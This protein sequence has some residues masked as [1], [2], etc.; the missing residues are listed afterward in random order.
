MSLDAALTVANSGLA[1]INRQF[2]LIS[3]NVANASTPS[4]AAEIGGQTALTA[5][6]V[7]LG[8]RSLPATR[9][10]DASLQGQLW[11]QNADVSAAQTRQTA[12]AAIDAAS[13]TTGA[14]NDIASLLGKLQ[15]AFSTLAND[16]S[17][18]T[19]QNAV[20]ADAASLA[21]GINTLSSAVS[22]ARQAA[23]DGIVS[24]IG[25]LNSALTQIGT[26]SDQIIAARA[27]GQ[28]TADLENQRDGVLANISQLIE[29]KA[30]A[31][32][33]GDMVLITPSGL[34]LPTRGGAAFSTQEAN[35]APGAWYPG[36]GVPA[37]T[38]NGV[39]V[40][41]QLQGGSIGAN[42]GLRDASL[43]IYQAGLDE[44]AQNIA[45]RFDAQGLRLFSDPAGNV[46]ASAGAPVQG[47]YVGFA[48]TI[49]V[50][51]A[52]SAQ[53]SL[54]RDGTQSVAG[55]PT[56]ASAFT[57]NPAGG[58]A[59]F[60]TLITR[61]LDYALGSQVQAGVAQ[62]ATAATGLGPA[63]NLSL[64]YTAAN[65]P[66][67]LAS[68]IVASQSQ[69]KADADSA[70]ATA[71]GMQ[72][73]VQTRLSAGSAVNIDTEMSLMVTLQNAYGAN[74]KVISAVQ[75]MWTQLLQAVP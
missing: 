71:Q 16:P 23:Q 59:G 2:A 65:T 27:A 49:G 6:G 28:S 56:G 68:S 8:V 4:Y 58:P 5:G 57:P 17:N 25:T 60:S 61:V 18:A 66:A 38:L 55:S 51:P 11:L 42:I 26:L 15:D 63:G 50:N 70:A 39:D 54:V 7:G 14:G 21:S 64:P 3:Q 31:Q 20:V 72:G 19:Q 37:I 24:G 62:P 9:N 12:L 53:P 29:V 52:V 22:T 32:P 46:P 67:G 34:S 1:N 69:D 10:V 44:F 40:T 43:P 35:L 48:A 33:N 41:T 74:A 30:L 36:G 13:G 45:S 47:A 73:S 75:A